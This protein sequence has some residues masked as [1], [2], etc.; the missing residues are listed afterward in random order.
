MQIERI[1]GT[2]SGESVSN[3]ELGHGT[4]VDRDEVP[5]PVLSPKLYPLQIVTFDMETWNKSNI[6][7]LSRTYSS[8]VTADAEPYGLGSVLVPLVTAEK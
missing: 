3:I 6:N 5:T 4:G 8:C 7:L 1:R 2:A